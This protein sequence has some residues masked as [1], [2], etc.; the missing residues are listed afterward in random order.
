VVSDLRGD[1]VLTGPGGLI[2]AAD[3]GTHAALVDLTSGPAL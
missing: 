2:A 3:A 1:P